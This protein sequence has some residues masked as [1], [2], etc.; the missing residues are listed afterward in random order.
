MTQTITGKLQLPSATGGAIPML[1]TTGAGSAAFNGAIDEVRIS[2]GE[3]A[4]ADMLYAPP[5]G[6]L[7]LM[8][9]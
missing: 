3:V 9:K 7:V 2:L 5:S 4:D 8:Y 1:G 6:G